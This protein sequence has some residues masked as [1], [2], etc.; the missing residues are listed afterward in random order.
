MKLGNW[1]E[2][3]IQDNIQSYGNI[4]GVFTITKQNATVKAAIDKKSA[5][6]RTKSER[7]TEIG[8]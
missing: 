4:P 1:C 6:V 7:K 5:E 2:E 3:Y 8:R